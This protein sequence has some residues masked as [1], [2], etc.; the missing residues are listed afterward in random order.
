[1]H[2]AGHIPGS[3]SVRL[4]WHADVGGRP[5]TFLVHGKPQAATVLSEALAARGVAAEVARPGLIDL[6]EAA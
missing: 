5:R 4:R 1:M 2:L 3:A 6:A